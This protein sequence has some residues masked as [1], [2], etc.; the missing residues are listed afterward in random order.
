MNKSE[1]FV[2]MEINPADYIN[3]FGKYT[4]IHVIGVLYIKIKCTCTLF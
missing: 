3:Y 2:T 4:P 1:Y